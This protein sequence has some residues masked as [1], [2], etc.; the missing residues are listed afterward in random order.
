MNFDTIGN[1]TRPRLT[2]INYLNQIKTSRVSDS[3]PLEPSLYDKIIS[4]MKTNMTNFIESNIYII[5][6]IILIAILLIYR[7]F[8]YK[9]VKENMTKY[10]NQD[11]ITTESYIE[12]IENIDEN[13]FDT[14]LINSE[15]NYEIKKKNII[16]DSSYKPYNLKNLNDYYRL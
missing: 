5:M 1:K 14:S 15:E 9:S 12:Q 3:I 13:I 2:D 8:Q 4:K 16:N 10:K 11:N 7:Y 6:I